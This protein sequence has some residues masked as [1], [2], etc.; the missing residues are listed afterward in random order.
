MEYCWEYVW[1][2][3]AY[4][5]SLQTSLAPRESNKITRQMKLSKIIAY[6]SAPRAQSLDVNIE[7]FNI[8]EARKF[9]F[10]STQNIE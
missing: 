4:A 6:F 3:L 2:L 1:I 9:Q 5:L 8:V 10:C 7:Y